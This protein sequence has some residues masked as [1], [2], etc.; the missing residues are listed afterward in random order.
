MAFISPRVP[1]VTS[2]DGCGEASAI[3][4]FGFVLKWNAVRTKVG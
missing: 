3:T 2:I 1:F 4:F